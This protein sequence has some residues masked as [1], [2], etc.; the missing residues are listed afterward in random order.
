MAGSSWS[1]QAAKST[2]QQ[3][4]TPAKAVCS[5]STDYMASNKKRRLQLSLF[6]LFP[7][8]VSIFLWIPWCLEDFLSQSERT[9]FSLQHSRCALIQSMI[10]ALVPNGVSFELMTNAWSSDLSKL[11]MKWIE[12]ISSSSVAAAH[13]SAPSS[14]HL[15]VR[16]DLRLEAHTKSRFT[17]LCQ[18]DR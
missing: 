14:W 7:A 2:S 13:C 11:C 4:E 17:G 3:P 5:R 16:A 18:T 1:W 8:S 12:W 6:S 15:Y 10:C 9:W